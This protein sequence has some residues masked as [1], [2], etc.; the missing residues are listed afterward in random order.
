MPSLRDV[1]RSWQ[2]LCEVGETERWVLGM[3]A[4]WRGEEDEG[5][6]LV[7]MATKE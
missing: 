1:E 2:Q 5:A 7:A 4:S 6:S 3:G